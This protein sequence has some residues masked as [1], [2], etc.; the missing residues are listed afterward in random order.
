V[1][2][3][4]LMGVLIGMGEALLWE[5]WILEAILGLLDCQSRALALTILLTLLTAAG[6]ET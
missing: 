2:S 6:V 5:F 1:K 4:V 3:V